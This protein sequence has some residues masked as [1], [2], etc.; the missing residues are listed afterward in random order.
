MY[1][2]RSG[3]LPTLSVNGLEL[4]HKVDDKL[5]SWAMNSKMFSDFN[6]GFYTH[7]NGGD[8]SSLKKA[9]SCYLSYPI[10]PKAKETF[11]MYC[12]PL[13]YL[14]V[15]AKN[16]IIWQWPALSAPQKQSFEQKKIKEFL[17]CF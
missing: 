13:S 12:I 8:S 14:C 10:V 17:L 16:M 4:F 11:K 6:V 9:L 1:Y 15:F 7:N 2:D 3:S 5:I